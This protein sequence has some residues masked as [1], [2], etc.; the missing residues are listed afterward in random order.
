[1]IDIDS[2]DKFANKNQNLNKNRRIL[3]KQRLPVP[4]RPGA[5]DLDQRVLKRGRE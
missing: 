2:D 5:L 1:M 4:A 3:P